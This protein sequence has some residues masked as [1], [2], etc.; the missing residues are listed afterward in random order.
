[1]KHMSYPCISVTALTSAYWLW[2]ERSTWGIVGQK[3]CSRAA[4]TVAHRT[5][6]GILY[7][8]SWGK[9]T[10]EGNFDVMTLT[11]LGYLRGMGYQESS[12]ALSA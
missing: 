12:S 5:A 4:R 11:L 3:E 10:I 9:A 6:R 8:S 1:M 2:Q 7:H